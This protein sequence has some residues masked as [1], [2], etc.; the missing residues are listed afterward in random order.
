MWIEC[1]KKKKKKLLCFGLGKPG[2]YNNSYVL[3]L[4]ALEPILRNSASSPVLSPV[5]PSLVCEKGL[6]ATTPISEKALCHLEAIPNPLEAVTVEDCPDD[7]PLVAALLDEEHLDFS[8]SE[9]DGADM[10][11]PVPPSSSVP[12]CSTEGPPPSSSK[13]PAGAHPSTITAAGATLASTPGSGALK[14]LF[15]TSTPCA[16]STR[17]QNFSLNHLS[18]SCAL[19]PE[20]F[21]P[22]FDVW[23]L[24]AIGY[25]AGKTQVS[26]LSMELAHRLGSVKPRLPFMI[27][28]G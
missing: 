23:N 25:V 24:C 8:L 13:V 17:L 4:Y 2:R 10:S 15:S 20:D 9:D 26:K 1:I 27:L 22:Q 28:D 14:A 12:P 3:A 19:S 7:D 6:A 5:A 16:P 11:S 18:R 21:Q